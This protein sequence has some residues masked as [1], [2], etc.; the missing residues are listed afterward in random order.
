MKYLMNIYY[1]VGL[2]KSQKKHNEKE[3]EKI[4]IKEGERVRAMVGKGVF[5]KE[6]AKFSTKVYKGLRQ[7]GYRFVL[8][9]EDG[10]E[11]KRRY[12]PSELLV[13]RGEVVDRLGKTNKKAEKENKK[14][15][16]VEKELKNIDAE[17]VEER[18]SK[19]VRKTRERLDL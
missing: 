4:D 9:N 1:M 16:K 19:R 10:K 12:R 2:Y 6:K 15:R 8:E 13:I 18:K 5:E 11:V 3:N 7:E 14:S 17:V